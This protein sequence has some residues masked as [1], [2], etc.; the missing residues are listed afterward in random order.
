MGKKLFGLLL[1]TP[2]LLCVLALSA[3]AAPFDEGWSEPAKVTKVPWGLASIDG[4]H[5]LTIVVSTGYCVGKK[6]PRLLRPHVDWRPGHAVI[7]ARLFRPAVH[8]GPHE[9]CGGVGLG[10]SGRFHF[11][12]RVADR[13]LYD[14][15]TSPPERREPPD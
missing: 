11:A 10:M 8:F 9:A 6:K 14:G 4:G 12:H 15:S 5:S 13:A 2:M 7:T 3:A 1:L